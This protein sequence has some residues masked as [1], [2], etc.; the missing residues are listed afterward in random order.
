[1]SRG[2]TATRPAARRV[3]RRPA[4]SAAVREVGAAG[5][6]GPAAERQMVAL[7]AADD[8]VSD[9]GE[10]PEGLPVQGITGR[11]GSY[12]AVRIRYPLDAGGC[13]PEAKADELRATLAAHLRALSDG[14]FVV[15]GEPMRYAAPSGRFRRK[16]RPLPGR[17][18]Q[19]LRMGDDVAGEC[20]G[21]MAFGGTWEISPA[22]SD[23]C[24]PWAGR[25]PPTARAG[26]RGG[27]T[28]RPTRHGTTPRAWPRWVWTH[29][30]CCE[31]PWSPWSSATAAELGW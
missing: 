14:E 8:R 1:M 18:V 29:S 5:M 30:A 27:P 13:M 20:V 31:R 28:T 2:V 7:Q 15:L 26:R 21:A 10:L 25:R 6:L 3:R 19:Y 12:V 4:L 11:H 22:D 23:G 17:Y 9:G 16:P 24:V